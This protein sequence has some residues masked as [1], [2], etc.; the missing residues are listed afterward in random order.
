MSLCMQ[1][2]P[3]SVT[4][5]DFNMKEMSLGLLEEGSE[6]EDQ[7]EFGHGQ[8][9]LTEA[10]TS[11]ANIP[12]PRTKK[13]RARRLQYRRAEAELEGRRCELSSCLCIEAHSAL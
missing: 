13:D 11:I 2:P 9:M 12:K 6:D 1:A 5:A 4:H 8:G 10:S 7:K 3:L